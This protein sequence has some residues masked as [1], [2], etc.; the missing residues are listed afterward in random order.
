L[1]HRKDKVNYTPAKCP[2]YRLGDGFSDPSICHHGI[3]G[4]GR[5]LPKEDW[6]MTHS[7]HR[8]YLL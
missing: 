3:G 5:T 8:L 1:S 2:P 6:G 4:L 7:C